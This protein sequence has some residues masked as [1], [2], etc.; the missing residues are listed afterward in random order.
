MNQGYYSGAQYIDRWTNCAEMVMRTLSYFRTCSL[1]LNV[2]FVQGTICQKIYCLRKLFWVLK[3]LWCDASR[4]GNNFFSGSDMKSFFNICGIIFMNT[5]RPNSIC[6]IFYLSFR[7]HFSM[8][9]QDQYGVMKS[10]NCC[11]DIEYLLNT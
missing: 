6:S 2:F 1:I 10:K 3:V 9:A 5:N 11:A 4:A 8:T 7:A